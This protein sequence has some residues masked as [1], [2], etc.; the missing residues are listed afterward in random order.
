MKILTFKR[1]RV[2]GLFRRYDINYK[3][4]P[5]MVERCKTYFSLIRRYE[6]NEI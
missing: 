5:F 4:S 2:W 6:K 1:F 3:P